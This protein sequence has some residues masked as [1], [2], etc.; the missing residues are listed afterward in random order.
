[1]KKWEKFE[2]DCVEYLNNNYGNNDLKFLK[3]GGSNSTKSD[4]DAF[5]KGQYVFSIEVKSYKA[6]SGQFVVDV[7]NNQF[8]EGESNKNKNS[9]NIHFLKYIN[10]HFEKFKNVKQNGIDIIIAQKHIENWIIEHYKHKSSLYIMSKS[11]KQ[12]SFI[13][14][15]INEISEH[16]ELKSKL[17]RKKSGTSNLPHNLYEEAKEILSTKDYFQEIIF[18]KYYILKTNRLL[19]KDELSINL[20]NSIIHLSK[21]SDTIY[22]INKKSKTNNVN[23]IFDITLKENIDDFSDNSFKS[24]LESLQY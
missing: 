8:V 16:F 1:M 9:N 20:S 21:K 23:V 11:I 3:N 7:Q 10:N 5:Y 24:K 13:I 12:D 19:N 22:K 15:P 2:S 18:D 6:Q 4:I 17:R 14:K